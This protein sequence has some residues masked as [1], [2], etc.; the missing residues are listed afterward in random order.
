MRSFPQAFPFLL[1]AS[2]AYADTI[3]SNSKIDAV[4][5]FPAAAL[6]SRVATAHVPKGAHLL[7]VRGLPHDLEFDT[8]RISAK[9]AG[10]LRI[11]A[12]DETPIPTPSAPKEDPDL[13]RK[14]EALKTEKE[15]VAAALDRVSTK[16]EFLLRYAKSKIETD[17]EISNPAKWTERWTPIETGL[18]EADKS[19]IELETR[20]IAIDKEIASFDAPKS[21]TPSQQRERDIQVAI[22]ADDEIPDATFTISYKVGSAGWS[23]IYDAELS[24]PEDGK[25]SLSLSRRATVRQSTDEDW[26]DVVLTVSTANPSLSPSMP[27]IATQIAK[28]FEAPPERFGG[29][30]GRGPQMFSET[31]TAIEGRVPALALASAPPLPRSADAVESRIDSRGWNVLFVTPGRVTVASGSGAK[32]VLLTRESATPDIS[33]AT[34]PEAEAAAYL[35]AKFKPKGDAPLFAGPVNLIHDGIPAGRGQLAFTPPGDSLILDFGPDESIKVSRITVHDD[36][37]VP[38]LLSMSG[39]TTLTREFLTKVKNLH[40]DRREV[41][42]YNRVPVS[43]QTDVDVKRIS[44]PEAGEKETPYKRGVTERIVELAPGE[45][46]SI[47]GGYTISYPYKQLL[48]IR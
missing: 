45:E 3:E 30:S 5:V 40:K 47:K 38:G 44:P 37:S 21:L 9:A 32:T 39:T 41:V 46:K 28:T 29:L 16:R 26:T 2:T 34:F 35:E 17:T 14:F 36:K 12:V 27:A 25:P 7:A 1:L 6:V 8:I 4:S 24:T 15:A 18:A 10:D 23:P 20:A 48:D 42:V 33:I 13:E 31:S 43:E 19:R 11:G 22:E